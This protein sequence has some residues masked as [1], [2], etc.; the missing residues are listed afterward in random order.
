[1]NLRLSLALMGCDGVSCGEASGTPSL[2]KPSYL[3]HKK[4]MLSFVV[5]EA[6]VS[7]E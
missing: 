2:E 4:K 1:M 5:S 3:R 7:V 6:I